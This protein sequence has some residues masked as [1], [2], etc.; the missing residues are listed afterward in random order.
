QL[1][2]NV[3]TSSSCGLCGRTAIESISTRI[4][5]VSS[6]LEVTAELLL[7]LPATMRLAQETFSRT[8]GLHAAGLFNEAGELLVL[9]EDVG[10]HNAVDKVIGWA[11]LNGL[12]PLSR[13]ILLISGRASFEIV[14][15]SLLAGIPMVAAVSAPSTLA[16][17][18]ARRCRQTLVGFLR[19]SSLNVYSQPRRVIRPTVLGCAKP[20]AARRASSTL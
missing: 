4:P 12:L 8:G 18:L 2:R 14:Q 5:K 16:V 15:K 13:H 6:E 11:L 7:T 10:R 19:D 9:R 20:L 17:A 3:Y 1:S